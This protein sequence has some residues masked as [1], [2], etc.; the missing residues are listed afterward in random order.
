ML[1]IEN[2]S[3]LVS[4]IFLSLYLRIAPGPHGRNQ[5]TPIR[6]QWSP[7]RSCT[8][9][10]PG[11]RQAVAA[12]VT[13]LSDMV[14]A[15][16]AVGIDTVGLII[17]LEYYPLIDHVAKDYLGPFLGPPFIK[18][19]P[20]ADPWAE[21]LMDGQCLDEQIQCQSMIHCCQ[22]LTDWRPARQ[23]LQDDAYPEAISLVKRTFVKCWPRLGQHCDGAFMM[24]RIITCN[25]YW[26]TVVLSPDANLCF[27]GPWKPATWRSLAC[28]DGW[29]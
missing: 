22:L 21:Q 5:G 6:L 18:P 20:D 17:P 25:D 14:L 2:L 28:V 10:M 4:C 1:D 15:V 12:D 23:A 19:D 13:E 16:Q 26:I 7:L 3:V 29:N 11:S 9:W 27:P 24:R 8:C